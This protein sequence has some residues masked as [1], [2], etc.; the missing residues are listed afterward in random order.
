MTASELHLDH[1]GV[2]V[3]NLDTAKETFQKLGFQLTTRSLHSGATSPGGPVQPWGTGNHCAMFADGYL[4]IIG[5]TDP[6]L[7]TTQIDGRLKRYEGLHIIAFGTD[8]ADAA[9]GV[10]AERIECVQGPAALERLVPFGNGTKRGRFRNIYLDTVA[11]PEALYIVIEHVTPD[12]L[13]Q[14]ALLS[15][16]NGVRALAGV[17]LCVADIEEV[18]A[19]MAAVTGVTAE[20][21]EGGGIVFPLA[22]GTVSI[23]GTETLGAL[24]PGVTAPT[25]P[26][27]AAHTFAVT[28]IAATRAVLAENGVAARDGADGGVWV[29][30]EDA[31]GSVISLI[32]N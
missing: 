10:L 6:D 18:S 26:Y 28:D 13:W 8:D 14:P 27:I 32:G 4:E 9:H 21:D 1:V 25:L 31:H 3:R 20:D 12:V 5:V 22:R 17:T 29:R 2:A 11:F 24:Y 7:Y 15:H 30:P 23:V 16:P 19:R